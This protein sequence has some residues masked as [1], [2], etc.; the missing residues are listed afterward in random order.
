MVTPDTWKRFVDDASPLHADADRR[1]SPVRGD[2]VVR[3][4]DLP[5]LGRYAGDLRLQVTGG[6]GQVSGPT[7]Y[8]RQ[9]GLEVSSLDLAVRDLGGPAGN[10]RR[11]VAAVDV[12][13]DAGDVLED[14][15]VHVRLGGPLGAVTPSWLAALDTIGEA[16]WVAALSL[17][18]A[19]ETELEA[20]IDA[21]MD[22]ETPVSFVGGS[23]EQAVAGL[24]TAARLW[25]D[26]SD[27]ARA[28]RWVRSWATDDPDAALD[29]LQ[30][31]A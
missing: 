18:G 25:G 31:L 26:E 6:A 28:R 17:D 9:H 19:G 7:A 16:E 21:A 3:D 12:A 10:V 2:R 13:L 1:A 4:E 29:H 11:L 30:G 22:R 15:V 27:L 8:C 20:W 14:T 5:G 23:V 24:T